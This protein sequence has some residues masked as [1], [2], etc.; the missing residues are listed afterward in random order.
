MTATDSA[1]GNT[2]A[3]TRQPVVARTKGELVGRLIDMRISAPDAYGLADLDD[4]DQYTVDLGTHACGGR[5]LAG[6]YHDLWVIAVAGGWWLLLPAPGGDSCEAVACGGMYAPRPRS[7]GR[8]PGEARMPE[9]RDG[10][11]R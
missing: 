6:P 5:A 1:A 11:G 3:D 10:G 7:A 8:A 2:P 4:G 9:P